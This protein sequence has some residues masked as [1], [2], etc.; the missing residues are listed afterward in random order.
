MQEI[1]RLLDAEVAVRVATRLDAARPEITAEIESALLR[2]LNHAV[3]DRLA[4]LRPTLEQEARAA[5]VRELSNDVLEAL[6]VPPAPLT[7]AAAQT[8]LDQLTPSELRGFTRVRGGKWKCLHC[9]RKDWKT[10][11]AVALHERVCEAKRRPPPVIEGEKPWPKRPKN[12][13]HV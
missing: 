9:Q 12:G 7:P 8:V 10:Q 2:A 5:L 1:K 13:Q 6:A 3:E 4:E 11:R